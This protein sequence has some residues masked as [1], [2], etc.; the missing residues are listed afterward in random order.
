[1]FNVFYNGELI[2]SSLSDVESLSFAIALHQQSNVKHSIYVY[3]ETSDS[4]V[5]TILTINKD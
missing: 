5:I 3:D 2:F 4:E 1:M